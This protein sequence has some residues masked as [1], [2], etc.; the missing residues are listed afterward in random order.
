MR[1]ILNLV[2]CLFF[3]VFPAF[4]QK[5]ELKVKFGKLSK[6]EVDMRQYQP[7]PAAPAVVLFDKG[8]VD[9]RYYENKGWVQEFERHIRIKI[10]KKEAY[11]LADVA[12]FYFNKWQKISELKAACYNVENGKTVEIELDKANVFNEKLTKSRMLQKFSI[13]GVREGSIIEYKFKISDENVV[14]LPDWFF[15]RSSVPT[16]WSEY[17]AEVP[18]FIE[19]KKMSQGWLPFALAEEE[20]LSRTLN[21][22]VTDRE[23]GR[24]A[25]TTVENIKVEYPVKRMRYI[26]EKVPALKPESFVAAPRD[27]LAQINFDIR[28][29]YNTS[30]VPSGNSYQLVNGTYKERNNTWPNL[31]KEMLED[32]YDELLKSGKYTSDEAEKCVAGKSTPAEKAAAIYEYIGKNYGVKDLNYIW[33]SQTM[34]ALTKDRKGTPTDLNILFVN[35]LRRAGL[36]AW[37]VLLSTRS[38]GRVHPFRV[39][40]DGFDRVIAAVGTGDKDPVLMDVSAFP[41]PPGL[42][43]EEDLNNEGLLLK[44]TEDVGWVPLQNKT[45]VRSAMMGDFKLLPEGGLVGT[46]I[47]SENGYGAVAKRAKIKQK[48]ASSMITDELKEWAS[49]G[50]MTDLKIE[51]GENWQDHNLKLGFKFETAAYLNA[52]GNK[53]YLTPDLGLCLRENPF[54]DPE[55][56]FNIDLG[57]PHEE[58]YVFTFNIP[59]GYKVEEQPKSFKMSFGENALTFDYLVSSTSEQIKINLKNKV[60]KTYI[61]AEEYEQL[62]QFFTELVAKMGEQIVLTKT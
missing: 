56:K 57:T 24:V 25:R 5:K 14:G 61:E 53:L 1:S 42:L 20:D 58:N 54:K 11:E 43:D 31:G 19:Y 12:I 37:P 29:V 49:E 21:F 22:N 45:N 52:A 39:S 60:K 8:Y 30:L 23:E 10:F 32:V 7:D 33:A 35:M 2:F 48:D 16:V 51:N 62:R 27:Y 28:A 34:E 38:H 9:H 55:R 40:P 44:S 18:T 59:V 41:N 4:S 15:Q 13:P 36:D 6:E 26:Q 46:V 47:L 17:E 3:F 50:K